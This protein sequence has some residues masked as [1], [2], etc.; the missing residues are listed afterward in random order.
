MTTADEHCDNEYQLDCGRWVAIEECYISTSMLGYL[1]GSPEN[2]RVI[3]RV[4][5]KLPERIEAQLG[6]ST[7]HYIKPLPEG[8][9]LPGFVFM[10]FLVSEAISDQE[11][12]YDGSPVID[13]ISGQPVR[14]YDGS[15]LIVCWLSDDITTSLPELV[16]RETRAIEWNKYAVDFSY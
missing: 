7:P 12:R 16:K 15:K 3:H 9:S 10:V 11:A 13:P 8:K 4:I 2:P 1:A 6:G 5:E 14:H